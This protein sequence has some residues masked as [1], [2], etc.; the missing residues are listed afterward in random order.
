MVAV[1]KTARLDA[2]RISRVPVQD[3]EPITVCDTINSRLVAKLFQPVG[4][5]VS[6]PIVGVNLASNDADEP[7][8]SHSPDI[9]E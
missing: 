7:E 2:S 4:P 6:V 9:V 3:L 8:T 1:S 5:L